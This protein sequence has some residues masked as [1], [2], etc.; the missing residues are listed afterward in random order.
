MKMRY[1]LWFSTLAVALQLVIPMTAMI[2]RSLPLLHTAIF[3]TVLVLL[4][5]VTGFLGETR[6]QRRVNTGRGFE[7]LADA[8]LVLGVAAGIWLIIWLE[9]FWVGIVVIL[10]GLHLAINLGNHASRQR[11][12]VSLLMGFGCLIAGAV[13]ASSA[14]YLGVVAVYGVALATCP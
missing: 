1:M 9:Q 14:A 8:L 2:G 7:W 6:S 11:H 5:T 10:V 12:T 13:T 3:G 4:S